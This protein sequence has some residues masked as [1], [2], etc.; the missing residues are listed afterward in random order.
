M[1]LALTLALALPSTQI[2]SMKAEM[3]GKIERGFMLG[4]R[5][6][7]STVRNKFFQIFHDSVAPGL[8]A[9]LQYILQ[10]QNW[11]SLKD[12][13]WVKQAAQLLLAASE[14]NHTLELA[15]GSS[16]F[17]PL[18][19]PR[20]AA[21]AAGE[22]VGAEGAAVIAAHKPFLDGLIKLQVC[23]LSTPSPSAPA[24]PTPAPH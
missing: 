20:K 5:C 2:A 11:E 19:F 23:V 8:P 16:A 21:N 15:K 22:T 4:L 24:S 7:D 1:T 9:R 12:S 10:V 18:P 13:F 14:G 3:I 6:G 17:A